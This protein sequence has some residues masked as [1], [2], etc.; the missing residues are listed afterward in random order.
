MTALKMWI[1]ES[2]KRRNTYFRTCYE[3]VHTVDFSVGIDYVN[4]TGV[5]SRLSLGS[6]TVHSV[7]TRKPEHTMV[8]YTTQPPE[9]G[10]SFS[11]LRALLF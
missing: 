4:E 8:L 1:K 6:S 2:N 9:V 10:I 11:K 3:F 5:I 7:S